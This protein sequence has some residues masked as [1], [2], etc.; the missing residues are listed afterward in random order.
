MK[1][2][3]QYLFTFWRQGEEN[4]P[5]L[6]KACLASMRA[7][8]SGRRLVVLDGGSVGDWID[9]PR[10]IRARLEEGLMSVQHYADYIRFALLHTYGGVWADATCFFSA[11]LPD[12]LWERE[13]FTL[14]Y[15]RRRDVA[16]RKEPDGSGGGALVNRY[17]I[18]FMSGQAG[19]ELFAEVLADLEAYW[20]SEHDAVAYLVTDLLLRRAMLRLGL[21]GSEKICSYQPG[22]CLR[23]QARL[24]S[25]SSE[26]GWREMTSGSYLHKC[27]WR[28]ALPLTK[29][30][31]DT[32]YKKILDEYR[33]PDE[34]PA[35][36][37]NLTRGQEHVL[38]RKLR[39]FAAFL[40]GAVNSRRIKA[41]GVGYVSLQV[42]E[43][44]FSQR[45]ESAAYSKTHRAVYEFADQYVERVL[46]KAGV[47]KE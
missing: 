10:I 21:W 22:A 20:D 46:K 26:E 40:P 9:V 47:E 33:I 19:N 1:A 45:P 44:I 4:A 34:A 15:T 11:D 25:A 16:G 42:L 37:G 17:A 8:V 2:R 43:K 29:N 13:F 31:A 24:A 39:S 14:E 6:V 35:G 23:L 28:I 38:L 7:H 3:P 30:G 18:F 5:P 27:T 36:S 32:F 12:S 41:Y